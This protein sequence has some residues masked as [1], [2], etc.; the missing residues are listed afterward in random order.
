MGDH[1]Q[2]AIGPYRVSEPPKERLAFGRCDVDVMERHEVVCIRWR[3]PNE[4]VGLN[5]AHLAIRIGRASAGECNVR[6]IDRRHAPAAVREPDRIQAL[7]ATNI[8]ASPGH[9]AL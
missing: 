1:D 9:E 4:H 2:R 3:L 6:K 7:A 8:Q 5:P